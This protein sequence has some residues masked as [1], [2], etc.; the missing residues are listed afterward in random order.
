MLLRLLPPLSWVVRV[1]EIEPLS[2][3]DQVIEDHL[4]G[5]QPPPRP[6]QQI[7]KDLAMVEAPE[8]PASAEGRSALGQSLS[9]PLFSCAFGACLLP[10][11]FE[12]F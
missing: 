1:V 6:L 4:A 2:Q 11:I 9:L 3:I 10:Q 5:V 12:K 7:P 8:K